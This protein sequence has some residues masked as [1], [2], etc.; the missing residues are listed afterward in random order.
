M[1]QKFEVTGMSCGHCANAVTDAVQAV[2]PQAQV[3]VDLPTGT[4]DVQSTQP[5]HELIAAIVQAGYQA[6]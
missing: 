2:D 5:R 6:A 4:V 3:S 1:H